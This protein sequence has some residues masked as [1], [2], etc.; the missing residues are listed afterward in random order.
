MPITHNGTNIASVFF[1]GVNVTTVVFNGT[2]VFTSYNYQWFFFGTASSYSGYDFDD[3]GNFG[4]NISLMISYLNTNY[5]P[6]DY[7]GYTIELYDF[8]QG[9]Y[10]LFQSA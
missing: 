5:P 7:A 3:Y 2:T 8:S 10:Y 6:N 1:N 4:G 9:I